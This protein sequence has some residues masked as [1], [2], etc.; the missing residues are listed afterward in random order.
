MNEITLSDGRKWIFKDDITVGDIKALGDEPAP[1]NR[2][3]I[4]E[5]N[6]KL[7]CAF[8]HEPTI[9]VEKLIA[10]NSMDY[11]KLMIQVLEAYQQKVLDFRQACKKKPKS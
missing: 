3:A 6:E 1:D 10:L 7:L 9:T 5:Y 8:S 4:T 11:Q 2:K